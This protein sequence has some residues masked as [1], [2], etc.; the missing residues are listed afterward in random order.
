MW[1]HL[2][3][4]RAIEA[5]ADAESLEDRGLLSV[6]QRVDATMV[7][8]QADIFLAMA[9]L[10]VIDAAYYCLRELDA[11]SVRYLN[12]YCGTNLSKQ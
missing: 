4:D 5:L 12:K 7:A 9:G 3:L 6:R 11:V 8:D 10:G 2:V 1:I